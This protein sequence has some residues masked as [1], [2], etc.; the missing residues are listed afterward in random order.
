MAPQPP[1]RPPGRPKDLEK[2]DAILAAAQDLFSTVGLAGVGIEAI[3]A[4]SGVSK[5]T[6]YAH[7]GDKDAILEALVA[8]ERDRLFQEIAGPVADANLE[9]RLIHFGKTLIE[10]MTTPC[11][12]ALDR[13]L[14]LAAQKNP[15]IAERFFAAGPERT[16]AMLAD[17]LA[18]GAAAGEIDLPDAKRGAEDLIAL[19]FGFRAIERRFK[20]VPPLSVADQDEL[21]RHAVGLFMRAHAPQAA[22]Q[23]AKAQPVLSH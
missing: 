18:V 10:I 17:I 2:R 12:L 19:W 16:R 11:H 20:A 14:S 22:G 21:I 23:A 15:D 4:A 1:G 8:R 6:V 7:F 3:A 5:V 9:T 13:C